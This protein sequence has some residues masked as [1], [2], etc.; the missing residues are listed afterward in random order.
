[1]AENDDRVMI[2]IRLPKALLDE[3][4]E[5]V[6]VNKPAVR[7]RTQTIEIALAKLLPKKKHGKQSQSDSTLQI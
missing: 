3:I 4:K 7:N 2:S 1:M 5:Y 6:R